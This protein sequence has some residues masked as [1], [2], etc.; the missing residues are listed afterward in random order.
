MEVLVQQV[1]AV[2]RETDGE[3]VGLHPL[4]SELLQR[5]G[6]ISIWV[7]NS[8]VHRAQVAA[9]LAQVLTLVRSHGLAPW[10]VVPALSSLR[11]VGALQFI[12]KRNEAASLQK[13]FPQPPPW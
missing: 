4:V 5:M 10:S 12:E 1:E 3:G 9:T 11:A 13:A 2:V 7:C 6:G 8:G